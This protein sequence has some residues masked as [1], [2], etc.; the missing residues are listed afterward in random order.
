ML[1]QIDRDSL[2]KAINI[3]DSIVSSKNI[4]TIL[5]NCLFNVKTDHI[6]I[7]STDN[8]I[9]IRTRIAARADGE[10]SFAANG[11]KFHGILKELPSSDLELQVSESLSITI[12]STS[13][14]I[15]GRYTIIGLNPDEFPDI[16]IFRDEHSIELPHDLMKQM[17][18]KVLYAAALETIKPVF[19]GI[20]FVTDEKKIITAVA[21]DSRRLALIRRR[22]NNE[23]DISDGI[24]I[25]VKTVN[26]VFRLLD[27]ADTC[28]L[29][30]HDNQCFFKIAD[31]EIISRIVDGQFPNYRQVLP[32]E[33]LIEFEVETK[34]LIESTRRVMIFTRE[35]AYKVILNIH[36]EKMIIQSSTPE[37]GEA[38]EELQ[39]KTNADKSISIG[40]NAQFLLDALKEI[41]TD[42]VK[43]GITGQM[44]PM[45][46]TQ[47]G[48]ES[49]LSIIMPIQIRSSQSE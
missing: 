19:N 41:D 7:V 12:R 22:F 46:I 33:F 39:V 15:K 10:I 42:M 13:K 18:R 29:L 20:Y 1:I 30:F 38:E 45:T 21:T 34:K 48:D 28:K 17:I 43:C 23:I 47:P 2:L 32:R 4:S 40:I 49:Y 3:A 25:P 8:D 11:K 35:P 26:E 16:P 31:T 36:G 37:L 9:A 27:S 5:S 6:E 44:S 14:D 24:I